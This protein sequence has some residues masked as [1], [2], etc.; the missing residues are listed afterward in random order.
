M[1]GVNSGEYK[2]MGLKLLRPIIYVNK[3][4]E[5]LIKIADDGSLLK[6][7]YFNYASGLTMT[8]KNLTT[9]LMD[10]LGNLKLN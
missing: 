8:N 7:S 9:F 6:M 2:V 3:I 4:K 5:N 10:C 1:V